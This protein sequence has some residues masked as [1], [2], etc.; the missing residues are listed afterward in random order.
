MLEEIKDKELTYNLLK[1][2]FKNY[3]ISD[4]PF[5]KAVTYTQNGIIGIVSYSIIYDRGEINY[6]VVSSEEHRQGIGSELL[7]YALEVS[8]ENIPAINLYLK[9]GFIKQSVRE[10]YYQNKDAYL[11]VKDLR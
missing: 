5:E 8:E 2:H 4:D 3:K 9:K 10:N 1:K 11:M 6:I 7:N